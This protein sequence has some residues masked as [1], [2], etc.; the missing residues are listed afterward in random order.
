D[1]LQIA[2]SVEIIL[3]SPEIAAFEGAER[4]WR[5]MPEKVVLRKDALPLR[6]SF[7]QDGMSP[8]G[9]MTGDW[10][11]A[12]SRLKV[13]ALAKTWRRFRVERTIEESSTIRSLHLAPADDEA[14]IPHLAGQHL[15]ISITDGTETIRRSY[16][17]SSAP[18]DGFYRLSVKREGRASTLLHKMREGD[19]IEA[20][21][22]A[23]AFTIDA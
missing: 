18:S 11:E 6:W 3:D 19:E 23:G 14:V 1:M 20:L 9:L 2:G 16:T 21:S 12:A 8:S 15:P 10:R 4:L 17:I 5:V 22:P 13:A 7:L